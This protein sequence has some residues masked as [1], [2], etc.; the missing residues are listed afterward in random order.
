[1]WLSISQVSYAA[2]DCTI[3]KDVCSEFGVSGYPTIKYFSYGKDP[4]D[5]PGGRDVSTGC[6][7]KNVR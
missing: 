6:P 5:F 2:V 1:M 4:V 7:I 3:H